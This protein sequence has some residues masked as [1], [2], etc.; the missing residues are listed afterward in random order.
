MIVVTGGAGFIGSNLVAALAGRGR[1]V[2]V[3]DL[4][5]RD[6]RWRNLAKHAIDDLIRPDAL[7]GFLASHAHSVEAVFHLGANSSTMETDGDAVVAS[8]IR[9]T[10]DLWR[11]CAE[12]GV[13]LIYASSAATYGDGSLGFDDSL[14]QAHLASLRPLNLYGWSKHM[15]DR[16]VAREVAEGGRLPPQW[17]GL[18]FFNV[19]GPNEYHKGGM[20]SLAATNWPTVRDGG[21]IRL[22]KS[23]S[24]GIPDGGQ[25]RD[26]I[27][28]DDC[29]AVMLFLLDTPGVS[30]LFNVGTGQARSFADL[31]RAIFAG[32]GL[33]ERIEYVEMPEALRDRY[34]YFTEARM[35]RLRRA[36]FNLPFRSLEDGIAEYVRGHLAA[37]DP[38]R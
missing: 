22:F 38:Y 17:A 31:A 29:V 34:Q 21:P 23:Y 30:G 32:A 6:E 1:R 33:P 7:M 26:F 3:C 9:P 36:G 4:L 24:D 18:K 14:D 12:N 5:G 20:R 8:N 27:H 25:K 28:V 2:V 10:L 13:R 15:V 11:W 37:P 35:D 16:H 19:Y